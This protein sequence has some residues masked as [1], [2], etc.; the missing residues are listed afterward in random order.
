MLRT[1]YWLVALFGLLMLQ[2]TSCKKDDKTNPATALI[3]TWK[4]ENTGNVAYLVF[5]DQG[6]THSLATGPYNLRQRAASPYTVDDTYLT[7]SITGYNAQLYAYRFTGDTLRL[8]HPGVEL[9]LTKSNAINPRD[10]VKTVRLGNGYNIGSGYRFGSLDWDGTQFIISNYYTKTLY[11]YNL[12]AGQLTDSSVIFQR[13]TAMATVGA[14]IWVNNASGDDKLRKIDFAT[15]LALQ[16]SPNAAATP[17]MMAANGTELWFFADDDK[18]YSYNTLRDAF[19]LRTA[20]PDFPL[21]S[22]GGPLPTDMVYV[23]GKLWICAYNFVVSFDPVTGQVIDTYQLDASRILCGIAHNGTNF[24]AL[25]L[26]GLGS[27][28]ELDIKIHQLQF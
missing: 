18:L 1:N 13:G 25:T 4:V 22:S 3:G 2:A 21:I 8:T 5:D 26:G 17:V 6:I 24:F 20:V 15:A 11:K 10:W 27:L 14:D 19:T 16:T 28:A 12:T 23:N 7:T 9:I